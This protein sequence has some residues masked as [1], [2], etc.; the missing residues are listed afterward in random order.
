MAEVDIYGGQDPLEMSLYTYSDAS[1]Y[2]GIPISTIKYWRKGRTVTNENRRV[3]YHPVLTAAHDSGLT[4]L[5][6]VELHALNEL[7]KVHGVS[8]GNIRRA[9]DYSQSALNIPRLLLHEELST[10]GRK[11]FIEYLG[12]VV[13]VSGSGQ[14]AIK[15]IL[16]R[17]LKRV[18]RDERLIPIKLYPDFG[19]IKED[20]RPVEI[21]PRVAF[22]KPT[23][24]GTGIHTAVITNRIDAGETVEEVALDYGLS[25]ELVE[26]IV[27]YEKAA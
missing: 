21:N 1:R 22:G 3:Q 20:E 26:K 9:L 11:V 10:Y 2:L 8:L 12:E 23:V 6:L 15:R 19:R 25:T 4:F 5:D 27:D 14:L 7:R 13:N 17:Y 16:E 24:A 18:E